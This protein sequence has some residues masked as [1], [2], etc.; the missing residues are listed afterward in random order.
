MRVA[1]RSSLRDPDAGLTPSLQPLRRITQTQLAATAGA[2]KEVAARA[3]AELEAVGALQRAK[4]RIA[5]VDR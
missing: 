5:L 2:V 3:V 4:G 1:P